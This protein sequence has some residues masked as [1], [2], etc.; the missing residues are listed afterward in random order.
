MT[1]LHTLPLK[2]T[3]CGAAVP[4]VICEKFARSESEKVR[5]A[6]LLIL[7][8]L[9]TGLEKPFKRPEKWAF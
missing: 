4:P 8:A 2:R 7:L 6:K 3:A 1:P 9:P 5:T